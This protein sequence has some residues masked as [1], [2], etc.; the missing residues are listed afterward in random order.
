[1]P[2]KSRKKPTAQL[3]QKTAKSPQ[4]P[5]QQASPPKKRARAHQPATAPKKR[6]TT[7]SS[8]QP[9]STTAFDEVQVLRK[10]CTEELRT[11]LGQRAHPQYA[12]EL[13]RQIFHKSG[14]PANVAT[15]RALY[16][17]LYG[18]I[19]NAVNICSDIATQ[20]KPSVLV[21]MDDA[22]LSQQIGV[23][24]FAKQ[25]KQE[26]QHYREILDGGNGA[27]ENGDDDSAETGLMCP[28]P[29][30]GNKT[31]FRVNLRQTRSADEPMTA[32]VTCVL[33]NRRFKR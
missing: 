33:C 23:P 7:K 15:M 4:P 27:G 18:R 32:F 1:M 30:C 5:P 25:F 21:L 24:D 20:F 6:K 26:Y 13:E 16:Y 22:T 12:V 10:E 3:E 14:K 17:R 28:N 29:K 19:L 11:V 31:K 8:N 2:S 9:Q